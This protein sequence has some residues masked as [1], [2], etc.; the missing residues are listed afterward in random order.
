MRT[1]VLLGGA[2][3]CVLSSAPLAVGD[4]PPL[5][6]KPQPFTVK[7]VDEA[8]HPVEGALAGLMAFHGDVAGS[9]AVSDEDHWHYLYGAQSAKDGLVTISDGRE[10]LPRLCV[11][12]RHR[13]LKLVAIAS[14]DPD[15]VDP[16]KTKEV[17]TVRMHPECHVS[18]KL[19]C[20]DLA[21]T[22]RL[23]GWTNVGLKLGD[24]FAFQC[25][26]NNQTFH[27][28]L[29]PG[30]YEA[31]AYGTDAHFV[32]VKFSIKA[33]ERERT[34]DPIELPA[35]KLALL[36]GMPAPELRDFV[37]WKGKP[38]SLASLKGKVVILDFWG[39][40]CGPCV[41]RMPELFELYDKHHDAGLEIVGLHVGLEE[42]D[43]NPVDSAEKLDEKLTG[44]R[45]S[46]WKGRDVPYP[47]ALFAGKRVSYGPR[48]EG[49][50]RSQAAADYGV[51][52]YP[53][54]ILIGKDGRVI[55]KFKPAKDRDLLE[56][57]LREE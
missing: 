11:V 32:S 3:L 50:A 24:K 4:D 42:D 31:E 57:I 41:H 21:K 19:S 44:I 47:V 45:K 15:K 16:L 18:G 28:I 39:Y 25:S 8:G 12:A 10:A 13:A 1:V 40:W 14:V 53:T 52:F 38:V 30:D 7:L 20:S 23:V 22:N 51:V 56:K 55:D 17:P 33:G 34:L 9:L 49:K 54:L 26:S 29:P 37:G 27:F 48:I 5:E 36:R 46:I 35:T 6:E 2:M 43:P